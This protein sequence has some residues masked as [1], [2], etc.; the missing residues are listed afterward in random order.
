M[1]IIRLLRD[2]LLSIYHK[3]VYERRKEEWETLMDEGWQEIGM[4]MFGKDILS[5]TDGNIFVGIVHFFREGRKWNDK[6]SLD[7]ILI[8]LERENISP[9]INCRNLNYMISPPL[10]DIRKAIFF[11]YGMVYC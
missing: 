7:V 10:D 8:T 5:K 2:F 11:R 1:D 3:H 4:E 9:I 6:L